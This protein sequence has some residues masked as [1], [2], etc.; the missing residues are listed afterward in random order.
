M[1]SLPEIYLVLSCLDLVSFVVVD[2]SEVEAV[3]HIDIGV[4]V[5]VI[6]V[7]CADIVDNKAAVSDRCIALHSFM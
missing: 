2:V 7:N 3:V 5:V 1:T 6:D 4:V